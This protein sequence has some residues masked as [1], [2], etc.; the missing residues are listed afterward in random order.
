MLETMQEHQQNLVGQGYMIAVEL[1]T[2]CVPA[3]PA[4]PATRVRYVV[5]CS[6]FYE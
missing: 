3:D 5:V 6:T 1:A 2:C 4:F